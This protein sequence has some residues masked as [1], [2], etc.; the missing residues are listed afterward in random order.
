MTPHVERL[1]VDVKEALETF[2]GS[3]VRLSV[4]CSDE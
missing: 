2:P 4:S 3:A 1:V